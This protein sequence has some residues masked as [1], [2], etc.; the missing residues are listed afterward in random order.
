[1]AVPKAHA[2]RYYR[3]VPDESYALIPKLMRKP[4]FSILSKRHRVTRI[5]D[6]Q[7]ALLQRFKRYTAPY[8]RGF[9]YGTLGQDFG[10][11]LCVAQH[12]GLP[13]LL[14]DWTLNPLVALYF[15]VSGTELENQSD[16]ALWV[17]TLRRRSSRSSSTVHLE[18]GQNLKP[19]SKHPVLV[20]P[21]PFTNRI[22]AQ[23]ARFTYSPSGEPLDS[24]P[25]STTVPWLKLEPMRV[26]R[27]RKAAIRAQ[28][29]S[30]WIHHGSMF[31]GLDGYAKYL[32]DGGM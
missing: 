17:M 29:Q 28:L 11:W 14:L 15:A 13:T 22:E 21:Q 20:V 24:L 31:P 23:A 30:L 25:V 9:A 10:E 2:R 26:D 3:G 8:S 32:N 1:M 16:G 4:T 6:L 5:V 12:H 27:S 18:D 7:L 19:H